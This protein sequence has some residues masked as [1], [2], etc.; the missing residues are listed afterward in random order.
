M[1]LNI[2]TAGIRDAETR[3]VHHDAADVTNREIAMAVTQ[4]RERRVQIHG[5]NVIPK[6]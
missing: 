4:V 6:L 1:S 5:A 3:W 2:A